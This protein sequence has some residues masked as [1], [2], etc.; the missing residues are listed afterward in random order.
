MSL[1]TNELQSA[2]SERHHAQEQPAVAPTLDVGL[3]V[4]SGLITNGQIR[5][6]QVEFRGTEEE[7][8]IAER[9]EVAKVSAVAGD[10]IVVGTEQNL[11]SAKRVFD[12]L[13]QQPAEGEAEK[14]VGHHV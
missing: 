4:G 13:P 7:V 14:L 8:E 3:T 9:I 1:L 10:G 5:N 6:A 2:S 11:G 12:R